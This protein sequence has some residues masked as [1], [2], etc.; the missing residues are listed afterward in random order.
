LSAT[1]LHQD[2]ILIEHPASPCNDAPSSA[3]VSFE[4]LDA[5]DNVYGVT[6]GNWTKKSPIK[7][8]QERDGIDAYRLA[9]Q[10]GSDR[11]S[12]Q[13]MG[14]GPAERAAPAEG[15]V[16][17]QWVEVAGQSGEQDDIRFRD[18]PSRTLPLVANHE[19]IECPN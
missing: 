4:E 3:G 8:S 5:R 16:D 17:V 12:E 6:E 14:H 11:H 1:L 7:D 15:M 19:V 9:G 10:S 13:S 18:R 2:F